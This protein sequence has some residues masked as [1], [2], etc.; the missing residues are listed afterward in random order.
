MD[1]N[2]L[3][4]EI[5]SSVLLVTVMNLKRMVFSEAVTVL[6]VLQLFNQLV[7][8]RKQIVSKKTQ[9]PEA[10]IKMCGLLPNQI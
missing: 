7:K 4:R 2:H 6:V 1:R 5:E 10:S 3:K 8:S 9:S